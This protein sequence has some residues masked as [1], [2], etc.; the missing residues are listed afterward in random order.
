M[1]IY[2]RSFRDS[3]IGLR[4][5]ISHSASG[6]WWFP[7]NSM[8]RNWLNTSEVIQWPHYLYVVI[9][10][11]V[12]RSETFNHRVCL[13]LVSSLIIAPSSLVYPEQRKFARHD[14]INLSFACCQHD[15]KF[16][17]CGYIILCQDCGNVIR[18]WILAPVLPFLQR[19]EFSMVG[20]SHCGRELRQWY[21]TLLA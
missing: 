5:S 15:Q 19:S 17:S 9:S 11:F 3:F 12:S 10:P 18:G 6:F 4:L 14:I 8:A 20:E 1:V 13:K 2:S 21:A 7:L 16:L